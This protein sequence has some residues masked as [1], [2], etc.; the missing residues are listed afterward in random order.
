M[1]LCGLVQNCLCRMNASNM[2]CEGLIGIAR[3][4]PYKTFQQQEER[5][6]MG[7]SVIS[8]YYFSWIRI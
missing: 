8:Q 6:G 5:S 2:L 3:A 1:Y 7:Y 4:Y